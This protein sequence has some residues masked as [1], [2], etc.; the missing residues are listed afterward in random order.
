MDKWK[1]NQDG[2]DPQSNSADHSLPSRKSFR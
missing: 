2:E 1:D